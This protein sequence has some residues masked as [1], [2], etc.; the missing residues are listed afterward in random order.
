MDDFEHIS[1]LDLNTDDVADDELPDLPSRYDDVYEPDEAEQ[2][3]YLH[4]EDTDLDEYLSY[5]EYEE[6]EESEP[7]AAPRRESAAA[8]AK[9]KGGK[10]TMFGRRKSISGRTCM[11]P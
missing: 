8:P 6:Q 2:E 3:A 9:K 11:R 4:P 5:S 10:I 7:E 1:D